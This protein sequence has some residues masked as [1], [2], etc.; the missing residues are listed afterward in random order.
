MGGPMWP[1][2]PQTCKLIARCLANPA[3]TSESIWPT[4]SQRDI[5][6]RSR[7]DPMC[8]TCFKLLRMKEISSE[9]GGLNDYAGRSLVILPK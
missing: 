5:L 2:D 6:G 9:V 8:S 4:W 1:A 3:H 7:P